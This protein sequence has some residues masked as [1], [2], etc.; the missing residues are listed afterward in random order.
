MLNIGSYLEAEGGEVPKW[1]IGVA[2]RRVCGRKRDW[3][4]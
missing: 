1:W 4:R 2:E 3:S